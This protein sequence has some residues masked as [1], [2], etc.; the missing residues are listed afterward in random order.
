MAQ[1]ECELCEK[2]AEIIYRVEQAEDDINRLKLSKREIFEKMEDNRKEMAEKMEANQ[3][4]TN[5]KFDKF[6]TIL[7]ITLTTGLFSLILLVLN[8][9]VIY[10]GR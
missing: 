10:G 4:E 1:K 7:I 3:E 5:R 9:I 8:L 6:N 2:P